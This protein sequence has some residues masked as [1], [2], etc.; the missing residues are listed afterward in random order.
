[1]HPDNM[2]EELRKALAAVEEKPDCKVEVL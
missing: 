2:T 1:M